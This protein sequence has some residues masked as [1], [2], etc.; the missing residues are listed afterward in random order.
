MEEQGESGQT[1]FGMIKWIEKA[2]PPIVIIENVYGAPWGLKVEIFE[3]RGYSATFLRLDTKDFYIPHTRQRGYLFAVNKKTSGKKK[4]PD[5]RPEMWKEMVGKLKRPASATLDEFM[6]PNDDPRVLRGRA[7]L[8]A[9]SV[10]SDGDRAGRTDW[11]KCETRHQD[12][13]SKELL[14]DKRPLT[15]WS[16]SGNTTTP[17]FAWNE[18]TNAQVHRIHDLMDINTL[19]LA[20]VGMDC[21]Y[22]TMVWNLSQNVDRETMGKVRFFS[23]SRLRHVKH[24]SHPGLLLYSW[25]C[26]SV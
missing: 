18:W 15:E 26:V 10:G 19:R 14:G 17:S 2:Q 7:R 16:D 12:A 11:T 24:S 1:F 3:E 13:R 4:V 6:L 5:P 25:D 21:T 8:T 20:K 22:K 23:T 9:E